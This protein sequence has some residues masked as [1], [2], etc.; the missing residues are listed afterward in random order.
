M[1]AAEPYPACQLQ[2]ALDQLHAVLHDLQFHG[3]TIKLSKY[4]HVVRIVVWELG[5]LQEL[6][7]VLLR[8]NLF[9]LCFSEL[10][11]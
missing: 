2:V 7:V 1:T 3:S 11:V 6:V 5:Q 10:L 9:F 4:R 8:C